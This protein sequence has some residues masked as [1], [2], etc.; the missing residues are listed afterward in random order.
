MGT[1]MFFVWA[2]GSKREG[3]AEVGSEKM[4]K[5]AMAAMRT[6]MAGLIDG[7]YADFWNGCFNVSGAVIDAVTHSLIYLFILR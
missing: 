5:R 4:L 1:R 3:W 2:R 6:R 7:V